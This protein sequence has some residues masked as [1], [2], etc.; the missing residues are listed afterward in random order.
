VTQLGWHIRNCGAF[1][2]IVVGVLA[3]ALGGA[4][5]ESSGVD[6]NIYDIGADRPVAGTL[7]EL[8]VYS[9]CTP[10]S[11]ML[12]TSATTDERGWFQ[13]PVPAGQH[14]LVSV[15]VPAGKQVRECVN[16]SPADVIERC[17][18]GRILQRLIVRVSGDRRL[19]PDVLVNHPCAPILKDVCDPLNLPRLVTSKHAVFAYEDNR[20][21]AN[22]TLEFRQYTKGK[23]EL[24]GTVT[25]D[26]NGAADLTGIYAQAHGA[27]GLKHVTVLSDSGGSFLLELSK[28]PAD[29][30][31]HLKMVTWKCGGYMHLQATSE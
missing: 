1:A 8:V 21:F 5:V 23:G 7:V 4:A 3:S 9:D 25:T 19:P 18:S 22:A 27:S 14:H 12:R 16:I 11:E 2:L 13:A 10:R 24:F 29:Q 26:A 20:P 6:F 17:G 28:T 30:P 31:Q 15:S